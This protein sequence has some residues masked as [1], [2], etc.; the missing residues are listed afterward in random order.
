MQSTIADQCD[1]KQGRPEKKTSHILQ[2]QHNK[3]VE[4]WTWTSWKKYFTFLSRR[5][6]RSPST[7]PSTCWS[8]LRGGGSG[9]PRLA[10]EKEERRR[11]RNDPRFCLKGG[12][13]QACC[14]LKMNNEHR[15]LQYHQYQH[16]QHKHK[17]LLFSPSAVCLDLSLSKTQLITMWW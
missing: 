13:R 10:W 7:S 2:L 6:W 14:F 11:K 8:P 9:E 5:A 17:P 1:T 4:G 3:R 16:I 12:F 15:H